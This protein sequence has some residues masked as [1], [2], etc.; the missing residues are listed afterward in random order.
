MKGKGLKGEL[1]KES[2]ARWMGVGV[3]G[4]KVIKNANLKNVSQ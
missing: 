1:V 4:V 3:E 2:P